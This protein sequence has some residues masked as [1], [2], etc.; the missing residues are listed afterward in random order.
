VKAEYPLRPGRGCPHS[1]PECWQ[2]ASG[3][4]S[5][6]S[7][8]PLVFLNITKNAVKRQGKKWGLPSRKMKFLFTEQTATRLNAEFIGVPQFSLATFGSIL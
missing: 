6:F 7:F 1:K 5:G 8:F 3:Q 4:A 2:Q